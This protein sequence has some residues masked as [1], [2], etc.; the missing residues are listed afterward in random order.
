MN[1]AWREFEHLSAVLC[2]WD[3]SVGMANEDS[4]RLSSKLITP[5]TCEAP[6]AFAV[7]NRNMMNTNFATSSGSPKGI[8][9]SRNEHNRG[10]VETK[11]STNQRAASY[12]C[13]NL[14]QSQPF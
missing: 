12:L 7:R 5:C 2:S 10:H 9:T 8:G 14:F 13:S 6:R 11:K 1:S 4:T 3:Q